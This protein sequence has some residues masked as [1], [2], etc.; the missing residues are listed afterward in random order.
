MRS[1]SV[2]TRYTEG[3]ANSVAPPDFTWPFE[4]QNFCPPGVMKKCLAQPFDQEHFGG[5]GTLVGHH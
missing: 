5:G 2:L 3:S 1:V 4:R